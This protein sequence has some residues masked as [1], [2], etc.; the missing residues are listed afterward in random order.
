VH[1]LSLDIG[2]LSSRLATRQDQNL[3]YRNPASPNLVQSP[4][5]WENTN[6]GSQSSPE[7]PTLQP[8]PQPLKS[9]LSQP[10]FPNP[11]SP[12]ARSPSLPSSPTRARSTN[13]LVSE[14]EKSQTQDLDGAV[15]NSAKGLGDVVKRASLPSKGPNDSLEELDRKDKRQDQ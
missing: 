14:H 5:P 8:S 11:P 7:L 13:D 15:S 12:P 9:R 1:D 10:P 3:S 6:T 4:V 2:R